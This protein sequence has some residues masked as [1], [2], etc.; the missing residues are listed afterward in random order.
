MSARNTSSMVS[1]I[2]QRRASGPGRI[3]ETTTSDADMALFHPKQ[4]QQQQHSPS[5]ASTGVP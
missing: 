2:L 1:R 5:V 3:E 4:Q